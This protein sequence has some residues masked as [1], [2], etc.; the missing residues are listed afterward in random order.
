MCGVGYLFTKNTFFSSCTLT[1]DLQHISWHVFTWPSSM[2]AFFSR[3][4]SDQPRP[5]L[6]NASETFSHWFSNEGVSI[7]V[8]G[9]CPSSFL[10]NLTRT[11]FASNDLSAAGG[12]LF[13]PDAGG[14]IPQMLRISRN[15]SVISN[16]LASG[17]APP[18]GNRRFHWFLDRIF[19]FLS[20][21]RVVRLVL[22]AACKLAGGRMAS[23]NTFWSASVPPSMINRLNF[24]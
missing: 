22:R 14:S 18:G 8:V 6:T 20:A 12:S 16:C 11:R 19:F 23:F 15:V 3:S 9:T 5:S 1:F 21:W 10:K 7:A 24:V 2:G 4:I 13:H 17:G